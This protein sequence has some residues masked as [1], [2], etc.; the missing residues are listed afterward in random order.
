M[1]SAYT[2]TISTGD[3]RDADTL[4]H[5]WMIINGENGHTEDIWL[6]N[7][8]KKAAVLQR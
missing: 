7:D 8:P 6:K 3:K 4:H 1:I 5:V 2:I